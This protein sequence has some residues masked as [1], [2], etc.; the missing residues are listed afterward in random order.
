MCKYAAVQLYS[1]ERCT[2]TA[3]L[4]SCTSSS[5]GCTATVIANT[6]SRTTDLG[7][8]NTCSC[9]STVP[10]PR[11]VPVPVPVHGYSFP[12]LPYPGTRSLVLHID[13]CYTA[14]ARHKI[15]VQ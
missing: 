2:R 4:Y 14:L 9:T 12:E 15:L 11:T 5:T 3:V 7:T 6:G 10:Y 1:I 13:L 8:G